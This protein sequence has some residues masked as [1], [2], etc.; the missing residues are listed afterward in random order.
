MARLLF[1][2]PDCNLEVPLREIYG[3]N[4]VCLTAL[5]TAFDLTEFEF[6]EEVNQIIINEN[7]NEI[8]LVNDH[9]CTFTKSAIMG[10]NRFDTNAEHILLDIVNNNPDIKNVQ[11]E[12]LKAKEISKANIRRLASEL[13]ES[14]F[15]GSK[16]NNGEIVMKAIIYNREDGSIQDTRIQ[17]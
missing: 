13:S 11:N 7:I 17:D 3:G 1:I 16:I 8:V 10:T 6:M 12:Q 4:S 5:G 2:C 9:A 14:A 15:I